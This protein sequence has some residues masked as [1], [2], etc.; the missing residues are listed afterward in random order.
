MR[1]KI[2]RGPREDIFAIVF[3]HNVTPNCVTSTE[4]TFDRK[5]RKFNILRSACIGHQDA[6]PGC[7]QVPAQAFYDYTVDLLKPGL[8]RRFALDHPRGTSFKV[9]FPKLA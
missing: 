4:P 7:R 5:A 1:S 3:R 2:Q 9:A 8:F 6:S